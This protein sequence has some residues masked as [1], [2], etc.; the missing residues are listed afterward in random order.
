MS[1]ASEESIS[2]AGIVIRR[3]AI[4]RVLARDFAQECAALITSTSIFPDV[5]DDSGHRPGNPIVL[6]EYFDSVLRRTGFVAIQNILDLNP[7]KAD[8]RAKIYI[9]EQMPHSLQDFH[10]DG[11]DDLIT[12]IHASDG[13]EFDFRPANNIYDVETIEVNARDIV[14]LHDSTITHRGSNPS[15]SVR[16]NAILGRDF[17]VEW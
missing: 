10:E 5:E 15:D 13:G 8:Q 2:N 7:Y 9:N 11:G 17:P 4:D 3:Q 14:E 12:I 16:Y 6:R 1:L